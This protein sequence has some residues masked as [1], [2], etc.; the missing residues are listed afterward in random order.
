MR[1]Q[2]VAIVVA[3]ALIAAAIALTN[4]WTGAPP[5][6]L[7]MDRWTGRVL[8]CEG[9]REP[10]PGWIIDCSLEARRNH[11]ETWAR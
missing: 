10:G 7:R 11:L 6:S 4:H 8:F 5:A 2:P 3:S 9:L 1:Q